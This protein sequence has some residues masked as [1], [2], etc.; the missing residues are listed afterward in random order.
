M[1]DTPTPQKDAKV[2][3]TEHLDEDAAEWLGQRTHAVW[4]FHE[5]AEAFDAE[6]ADAEGLVVRTYTQV[7]DA[8]LDKAPNL[9]VVGRAGVGLDNIDLP[10]C[11]KRGV[12][13]VYT[14]D[15]NTQAVVEYVWALIFDAIR[16]RRYMTEYAAPPV[17]HGYRKQ[18]VG[19]QVDQMTL[20]VLG[21]GRIG[22]RVAQ[23]AR[24]FG[25]R[26]IY[27]DVLSYRDLHLPEE[28]TSQFVDTA[29]LF[30]ESDIL[31]VHIDGRPSNQ[32][33]IDATKLTQMNPGMLLINTSRGFVIDPPALADWAA[34]VKDTGGRAVLDVHAPEPPPDDYPLFGHDNVLILPHLASRTHRAMANMSLVVR[35]VVKVLEGE[36]PVWPA[37]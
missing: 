30:A 14:P 31:T 17:F 12:R 7:N 28:D 23:V 22:R 19:R 20:G 34:Q 1:T 32:N 15:A 37:V 33:F 9:K 16:P 36:E 21:M 8:L 24:A 27:N 6:L 2:I 25:V 35:D 3:I 13:V 18:N 26:V 11:E 5:D 4:R 10:A 29:T